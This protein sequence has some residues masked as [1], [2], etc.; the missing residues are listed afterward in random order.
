MFT[1]GNKIIREDLNKLLPIVDKEIEKVL[2]VNI[3]IET[4]AYLVT[5]HIDKK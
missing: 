3:L 5:N 2:K 4:Q 1:D